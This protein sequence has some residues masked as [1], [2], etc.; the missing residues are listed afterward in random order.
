MRTIRQDA[1]LADAAPERENLRAAYERARAR[2]QH[3][4]A[5]RI[6]TFAPIMLLRDRAIAIDE[7][8]SA[9]PRCPDI[10]RGHA[11]TSKAQFAFATGRPA[12]GLSSARAAAEIF[13]EL[14][15]RRLG[16]WARYF[17]IFSAWGYLSDGEVRT[18][19][20]QVLDEFR[21]MDEQLGLAYM[22]WVLSQ[23]E[24]D[25]PNAEALAAESETMFRAIDAPFGLAH[26]LEGRALVSLRAGDAARSA[27]YLTQVVPVMAD[28]AEHGCLAHALEAVA[29]V[30]IARDNVSDART[31]LGA[32]EDLRLQTGHTHRP[33]ELR[34]RELAEEMLKPDDRA[35]G[36]VAAAQTDLSELLTHTMRLLAEASTSDC[37][38]RPTS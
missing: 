14:G 36:R 17:E 1:T 2:Q 26:C 13:D 19:V 16:A 15:D 12:Q 4:L 9:I 29:A 24:D 20:E 27:T 7:L 18:L 32:A 35:R 22:L 23:L 37:S 21:T 3:E 28:S 38:N 10:L 11:L 5:L 25:I 30:F 6:V 34:S 8:L 31:L 33:W